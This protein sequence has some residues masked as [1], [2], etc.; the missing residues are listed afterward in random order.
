[1]IKAGLCDLHFEDEQF[2]DDTKLK[3][4]RKSIPVKYFKD[5]SNV[6]KV[7]EMQEADYEENNPIELN[8]PQK[9]EIQKRNLHTNVLDDEPFRIP[10]LSNDEEILVGDAINIVQA[11]Q[12]MKVDEEQLAI[13]AHKIIDEEN[14]QLL[15]NASPQFESAGASNGDEN[16][17]MELKSEFNTCNVIK[18]YKNGKYLFNFNNV[19]NEDEIIIKLDEN[20]EFE[21]QNIE[22]PMV[23]D[24]VVSLID[25][26]QSG[27]CNKKKIHRK[28]NCSPFCSNIIE[29]LT[30]KTERL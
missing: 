21:L 2:T 25:K 23:S 7:Q 28:N 11:I 15:R 19:D 1:M 13:N 16:D 20:V 4:R 3:I 6:Q 9:Q 12:T 27:K 10:D 26:K 22:T 17:M 5:S 8:G 29:K 24:E 30:A 18:T 14:C